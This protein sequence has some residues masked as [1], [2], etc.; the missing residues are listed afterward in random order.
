MDP[1]NPHIILIHTYMS[2]Q[3]VYYNIVLFFEVSKSKSSLLSW[4][5]HFIP[6]HVATL[7]IICFPSPQ[8]TSA[9]AINF[10]NHNN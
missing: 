6:A 2:N 1:F 5:A 8:N 3:L 4:G 7:D 10:A 9:D